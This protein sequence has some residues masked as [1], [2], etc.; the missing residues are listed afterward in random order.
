MSTVHDAM[1]KSK[2]N[3]ANFSNIFDLEERHRALQLKPPIRTTP[4]AAGNGFVDS[5]DTNAKKSQL[6]LLLRQRRQF[7]DEKYGFSNHGHSHPRVKLPDRRPDTPDES[8]DSHQWGRRAKALEKP[9]M[10]KV[11]Q[12]LEARL[13]REEKK[14]AKVEAKLAKCGPLLHAG[15]HL[16]FSTLP[17]H[18][19]VKALAAAGSAGL[20]PEGAAG[21]R[22]KSCTALPK[23][24]RPYKEDFGFKVP[25][26]VDGSTAH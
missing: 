5:L 1:I 14:T 10:T 3:A 18:D 2:L 23:P 17:Y 8:V 4:R 13:E 16:S 20:Y 24:R 25:Y 21:A 15:E 26:G 22:P 19:K 11:L 7:E 6:V 12:A 9:A